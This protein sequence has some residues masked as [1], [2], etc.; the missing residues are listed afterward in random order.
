MKI[1]QLVVRAIG[2]SFVIAA[3]IISCGDE[4][5]VTARYELEKAYFDAEK[6]AGKTN[7]KPE[8]VDKAM[9]EQTQAAFGNVARNGF[10]ALATV[11]SATKSK[12]FFEVADLTFRGTSRYAQYLFAQA[13][14]DSVSYWLSRL[15]AEVPLSRDQA[16]TTW[17]NLGQA[18]QYAGRGDSAL[19]KYTYAV[20][21]FYPPID[22]DRQVNYDILNLPMQIHGLLLQA[23][24]T[25]RARQWEGTADKYYG[26]ITTDYPNTEIALAAQANLASVYDASG[27][28]TQAIVALAK[29]IDST[30]QVAVPARLKIGDIYASELGQSDRAMREYV[31]TE[32]QLKGGDTLYRPV[33]LL[34]RSIIHLMDKEYAEAREL[35]VTLKAKYPSYFGSNPIAQYNMAQTFDLEGNW[36]R[37]ETEYK[38]LITNYAGSNE[39][40][41]AYLYLIDSYKKKGRTTE[42]EQWFGKAERDFAQLATSKAGTPQEGLALVFTAELYRQKEDWPRA[43]AML[44][45]V[46]DKFPATDPGRRALVSAAV[47]YRE[48]LNNP[49]KA[50]SLIEVL[51]QA[52]LTAAS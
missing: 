33:I 24:D 8:L 47:I 27:N 5:A 18:H 15:I 29:V 42:A 2:A 43:A 36:E 49:A 11:D 10:A 46:Y 4:K 52:A 35:L 26:R 17:Y 37:A 6:L 12:E 1:T 20:E 19:T 9:I 13:Q 22:A 45:Q 50:D 44:M 7:I 25:V 38:F 31:E 3:V 30:G 48:K 21:T 32:A 40:F 39:A 23:E 16:M 34:K 14:F 41:G 51:K 28:Y